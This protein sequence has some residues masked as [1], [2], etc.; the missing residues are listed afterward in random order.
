MESYK[1]ILSELT[2]IS[3]EDLENDRQLIKPSVVFGSL[4]KYYIKRRTKEV[5]IIPESIL[6]N[7]CGKL[8]VTKTKI[9]SKDR[10]RSL[11]DRRHAITIK[12]LQ[13]GYEK[14]SVA[15]LM[16]RHRSNIYNSF[17]SEHLVQDLINKL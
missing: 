1:K 4:K 7:L 11:A 10:H 8:S 3:V 6:E 13:D 9:R 15:I 17:K 14:D 12:L 16:N 2:G 5:E